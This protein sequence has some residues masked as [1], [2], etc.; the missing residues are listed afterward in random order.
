MTTCIV[1]VVAVIVAAAVLRLLRGS[2]D[3]DR[4]RWYIEGRG[5]KLIDANWVP[6]GPG[7]DGDQAN[8]TYEVRYLDKD[9]NR[10]H[11]FCKTN[12]SSGVYFTEDRIEQR[13][14]VPNTK[15]SLEEENRRLREELERLKRRY[16]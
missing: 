2:R 4:I 14:D 11:A 1:L 9:G 7:W 12:T 15:R 13:T 8:R 3:H 5:G 16:E 6:F 10:H